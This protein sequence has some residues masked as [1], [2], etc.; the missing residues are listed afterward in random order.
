MALNDLILRFSPIF[1]DFTEPCPLTYDDE[2][3]KYTVQG[4]GH[5]LISGTEVEHGKTVR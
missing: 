3:I 2:N 1:I 5:S 4:E